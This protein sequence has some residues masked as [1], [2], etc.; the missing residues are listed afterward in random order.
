LDEEGFFVVGFVDGVGRKVSLRRFAAASLAEGFG[1]GLFGNT[2]GEA[3]GGG[4]GVGAKISS[5][6]SAKTE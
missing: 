2:D 3:F 4:L 1:L 6:R 5:S